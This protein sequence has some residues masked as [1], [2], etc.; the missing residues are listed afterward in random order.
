MKKSAK[1]LTVEQELAKAVH[2]MNEKIRYHESKGNSYMP[3]R[4]SVREIKQRAKSTADLEAELNRVRRF[5]KAD[6]TD[7][8]QVSEG[9]KITR[10]EKVE[11]ERAYRIQNIRREKELNKYNDLA[12][13][14]RGES[15]GVTAG[16]L[17]D[18]R[19]AELM[20]KKL[21]WSAV[22]SRSELQ[23]KTDLALRQ[24]RSTYFSEKNE[25]FK[26]NYIQSLKTQF[27]TKNS[28]KIRKAVQAMPADQVVAKYYTDTEASFTFVY[29]DPLSNSVKLKALN[30]VWG[31]AGSKKAAAAIE[32]DIDDF[33]FDDD[34]FD[35]DEMPFDLT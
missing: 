10:Y 8:V 18:D 29:K 27:G 28:L 26:K 6:F 3:K 12:A 34:D 25:Q 23:A 32:P 4:E 35:D 11:T 24:A 20:P 17:P 31:V 16:Q 2:A 30:A 19:V 21:N 5:G 1:R 22:R 13:T 14:S 7:T 15:L 33:D 9:L